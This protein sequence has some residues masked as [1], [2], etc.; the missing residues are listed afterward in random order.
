VIDDEITK[1]MTDR[2]RAHLFDDRAQDTRGDRS[3]AFGVTGAAVLA[4]PLGASDKLAPADFCSL[5]SAGRLERHP[6][7]TF[8]VG[9]RGTELSIILWDEY[10]RKPRP[11][12][13]DDVAASHIAVSAGVAVL[14]N[15]V[16]RTSWH[17]CG[18]ELCR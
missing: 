11:R 1:G 14:Y 2:R 13:L 8:P 15:M 17:A 16:G 9:A 12:H 18:I 5:V 3:I 7:R 10:R 6:A 4:Q